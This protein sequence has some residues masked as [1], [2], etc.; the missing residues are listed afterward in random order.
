MKYTLAKNAVSSLY[1][2]IENFKKFFYYKDKYSPSEIDESLK[3]CIVFLENAIELL[4]KAILV[5]TDELSIYK[6]PKSTTIKDAHSKVDETNKLE[7]ILLSEKNFQ[8]I[9]YAEAIK[10]YNAKYYNSDKLFNV[11]SNL[12]QM[13]NPIM[14]FGIDTIN[15]NET[16]I[17]IINV[18]DIIY[19][20]L[21]PQLTKIESVAT[22]FTSDEIFV[23]TIHGYKPLTDNESVYNNMVDFIDELLEC[24]KEYICVLRASNPDSKI[25]EFLSLM[26][27]VFRDKKFIA[28]LENHN[29][30][31]KFSSNCNFDANVFDFDI[32]KNSERCTA[33]FSRYSPYFNVTSFCDDCTEIRFLVVHDK[34]ELYVYSKD[35]HIEY[36]SCDEIEPEYH[37]LRDLENG[38]C[39]KFT[40]S[41][42]N[43]AFAL[44]NIILNYNLK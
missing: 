1:I 16:I 27:S 2:A 7:D 42:R 6:Y 28:M 35:T 21:Y 9:S 41:K 25:Y 14:H 38:L 8:T 44:E 24:T 43:L 23:K 37:W 17:S 12:G 34:H 39:K 31:I 29:V 33:I 15:F 26:K 32:V 5:E 20:Y 13:R 10:K 36:T 40:L 4:L 19:N 3:I 30:Q 11:L 18:F 22:Y